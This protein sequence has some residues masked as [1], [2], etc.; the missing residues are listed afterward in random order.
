MDLIDLA[1]RAEHSTWRARRAPLSPLQSPDAILAQLKE[2]LASRDLHLQRLHRLSELLPSSLHGGRLDLNDTIVKDFYGHAGRF[3]AST[4]KVCD[5]L[6]AW[7]TASWQATSGVDSTR[8]L[9]T[10]KTSIGKRLSEMKSQLDF[11]SKVEFLRSQTCVPAVPS[12]SLSSEHDRSELPVS[13][14]NPAS[15]TSTSNLTKFITHRDDLN[16][17]PESLDPLLACMTLSG[18]PIGEWVFRARK[19]EALQVEPD[20]GRALV[21]L[22]SFFSG[23]ADRLRVA[24]QHENDAKDEL[25]AAETDIREAEAKGADIASTAV[26]RAQE[27]KLLGTLAEINE[28]NGGDIEK[29][30]KEYVEHI[31]PDLEEQVEREKTHAKKLQGAQSEINQLRVRAH[32]ISDEMSAMGTKLSD[33]S[34]TL[35]RENEKLWALQAEALRLVVSVCR[36]GTGC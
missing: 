32:T 17:V 28:S 5:L 22:I 10:P 18:A 36:E 21:E 1:R 30:L 12:A 14:S 11:L 26:L 33:A 3:R 27:R 20:E 34:E 16:D 15:Q 9:L 7:Q 25:R 35:T 4:L 13:T 6:T 8:E 19:S 23:Q 29:Q 2:A 31:Y 24:I